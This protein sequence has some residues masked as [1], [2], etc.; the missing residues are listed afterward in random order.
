M[1]PL[2]KPAVKSWPKITGLEAS[3]AVKFEVEIF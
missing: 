2:S 3:T 1:T